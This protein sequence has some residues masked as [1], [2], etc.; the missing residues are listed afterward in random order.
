[1]MD[2]QLSKGT[3]KD[4][5]YNLFYLLLVLQGV[6]AVY[7]LLAIP[8]DPKKAFIG[9]LSPERLLLLGAPVVLIFIGGY[10][11]VRAL[12]DRGWLQAFDHRLCEWLAFNQRWKRIVFLCALF[13]FAG[14]LFVLILSRQSFYIL[15]P[16]ENADPSFNAFYVNQFYQR[17]YLYLVRLQPLVV[18]L[19]GVCA[20][21]AILLPI[22][23]FGIRSW[24]DQLKAHN[25]YIILGLFG[26]LLV[27]WQAVGWTQLKLVPDYAFTGWYPLG[28][29]I[30]DNQVLLVFLIGTGL[31]GIGAL[32]S[33]LGSKK[34]P[35]EAAVGAT[36]RLD[37][38]IAIAIWAFAALYWLSIPT[39]TNWFVSE[40]RYPNFQYYPNSDAYLYDTTAQSLIIGAGFETGN[41]GYARRPVYALFLAALYALIGQDYEKVT[42]VQS[43]IFAVFPVLI[44]YLTVTMHNRLSGLLA[45]LL[46]TL[47]E[48]NA[49]DLA[50]KITLSTSRMFMAE[51]PAA[52]GVVLF[53][54]LVLLWLRKTEHRAALSLLLG[55]VLGVFMQIRV[56]VGVLWP[57]FLLLAGFVT[58]R[59]PKLWLK[60]ALL[61][62]LG[63]LL[64]LAPWIWRN[65]RRTGLAYLE[66][67]SERLAFVLVR[68]QLDL[69]GQPPAAAAT[70]GGSQTSSNAGALFLR[71]M[72]SHYIN[73]QA[74]AFLIFP[75][76]FRLLDSTVGYLEQEKSARFWKACC[77][78]EDY[79]SRF[80]FWMWR[81]WEG[82]I[83]VESVVPI[84][85]NLLLIVIGFVRLWR[86]KS[87]GGIFLFLVSVGYYVLTSG[88]RVSGGRFVQIVDWIWIVYFS[89]G[90]EHIVEWT[91]T[92]L[93]GAKLPG[94]LIAAVN[95]PEAAAF[96]TPTPSR[97]PLQVYAG[98]GVAIIF[99][100]AS[101]PTAE[102]LIKPRY[103]E[104]SKQAWLDELKHSE[105]LRRNYPALSATLDNIQ[106][107]NLQVLQGR[108]LYPRYYL[109]G[110]GEPSV[111][112]TPFT[113]RDFARFSFYLVGPKKTGVLLPLLSQ[114]EITFPNS[115]D[116][117]VIGCQDN[118]YLRAWAVF[119]RS[120]EMVLVSAPLP[121]SAICLPPE[122]PE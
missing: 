74:Q 80:T 48:G 2:K 4:R 121:D 107:G 117:L 22:L 29:P 79:I 87:P 59:A 77:S 30:L 39:Q 93:S 92:S 17:A 9:G 1:M 75:D 16:A 122:P 98:I 25:V 88:V 54:C 104:Q 72:R 120:P 28:A 69:G 51:T 13:V 33:R 47:R 90:L 115:Q 53:A 110:D 76:A 35:R 109:A 6:F 46:V 11:W 38:I 45:A 118:G 58:Y 112:V 7:T 65:W 113:P 91:V 103:T 62:T 3:W 66:R 67:P 21:T 37:L 18:L 10:L 57:C 19:V 56:E 96:S 86:W 24:H 55:G 70:P 89:V 82:A 52:I 84:S 111:S 94:W 36:F 73:S 44:Y 85:V 95:A 64:F 101:L 102:A 106:P 43:A 50:D 20:Q 116:V 83:P 42:L 68:S 78:R 41:I 27:L 119:T 32:L 49:I 105:E 63:L 26:T 71:R 5:L 23:F 108:A 99:L 12:R 40:P 60:Y 100:G 15:A 114:P 97:T 81:K 34:F 61:I 8:G 31:A 14:S